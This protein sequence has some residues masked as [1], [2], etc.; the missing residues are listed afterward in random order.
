MIILKGDDELRLMREAGRIVGEVLALDLEFSAPAAGADGQA[1]VDL[2][3]EKVTIG[4]MR[5]R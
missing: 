2:A 1:E 5:S 3:G 4:V